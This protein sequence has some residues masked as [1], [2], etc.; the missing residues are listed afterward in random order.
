MAMR[1]KFCSGDTKVEVTFNALNHV[2]R[3]RQCKECFEEFT[4][5]EIHKTRL[6]K[7]REIEVWYNKAHPLVQKMQGISL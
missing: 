5:Y 1:C 4:T 2:R 3:I 7:L 6:D